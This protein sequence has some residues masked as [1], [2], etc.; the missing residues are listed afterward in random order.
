MGLI[1][2]ED[3]QWV[4]E[5][6]ARLA[7]IINEYDPAL[8]LQWIP[9]GQRNEEADRKNPYRIFDTRS[10]SVVMFASELDTPEGILARLWGA[11]NTKNSVL[12]NLDAN[13]AASEAFRLKERMDEDAL[14]QDFVAHLIGTKK[15]FINT[16]NPVTG[17]KVKFDDQLRRRL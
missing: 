13:N 9:P 4:N 12:E 8:S 16:T 2:S 15:N 11:D 3:G 1:V 14:K 5:H 6:F 10:N 7:E 17:E